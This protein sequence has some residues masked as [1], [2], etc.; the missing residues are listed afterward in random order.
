MVPVKLYTADWCK[1]CTEAKRM[2]QASGI[3]YEEIDVDTTPDA[4]TY[5]K[6]CGVR[7]IPF[8]E[9]YNKQGDLVLRGGT[10]ELERF[11]YNYE[12]L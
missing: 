12:P 8:V 5:L 3:S 7:T 2:L 10:P 1:W 11:I 4:K 6:K 9:C